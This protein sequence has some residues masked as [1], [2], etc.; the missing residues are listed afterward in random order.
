[1]SDKTLTQVQGVYVHG[2][3]SMSSTCAGIGNANINVRDCNGAWHMY[4]ECSAAGIAVVVDERTVSPSIQ[5]GL[6]GA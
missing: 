1:M 6:E 5:S 2:Q 3:H 4:T